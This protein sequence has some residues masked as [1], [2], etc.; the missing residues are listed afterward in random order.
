MPNRVLNNSD[1]KQ[2]AFNL[3][4]NASKTLLP[5]LAEPHT[6]ATYAYRNQ[7]ILIIESELASSFIQS[8]ESIS[9]L[10]VLHSSKAKSSAT[11]FLS[12]SRK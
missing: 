11:T 1:S 4:P 8:P 7:Q 5:T 12:Y 2:Q 10:I 9:I 3:F 6:D